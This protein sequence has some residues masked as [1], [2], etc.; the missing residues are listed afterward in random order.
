[1]IR[2]SGNKPRPLLIL[3]QPDDVDKATNQLVLVCKKIS[4]FR[5]EDKSTRI[6]NY[7]LDFVNTCAAY[8]PQP[9]YTCRTARNLWLRDCS[10]L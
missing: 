9:N 8:Q 1:M 2:I 6:D 4:P 7:I 10:L 3:A 5:D